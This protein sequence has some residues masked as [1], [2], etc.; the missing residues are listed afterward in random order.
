MCT[1]TYIPTG[2]TDFILTSNR[3]EAPE[4]E[5]IPPKIYTEEAL[6]LLY[7]KDVLA[8]G[9]WIGISSRNRLVNLM[10]GGF[11]PHKR[12]PFYRKSRGLVVKE[13]LKVKSID[14]YLK[15]E[16]FSEIEPFTAIVV[17]WET[18]LVLI[19]IVWDGNTLHKTTKP[20]MPHIWSSSPLYSTE[21]QQMRKNWF[22]T[23][24]EKNNK[25]PDNVL[26]FH[27]TGGEGNPESNLIMDRGVVKT[28]SITQIVKSQNQIHMYYDDL[29][30]EEKTKQLFKLNRK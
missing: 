17:I 18:D 27:R 25:S 6:E 29:Q 22:R 15:K 21:F 13:L 1:V 7:P 24:L 5:T 11:K 28:K 16:D 12:K 8:G 23:F 9:T 14:D 4:R 2:E 30:T 20:Q 3:D 26:H 19:E 10:N